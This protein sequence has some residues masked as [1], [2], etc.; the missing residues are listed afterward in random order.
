MGMTIAITSVMV[1]QW[2]SLA[3][4]VFSYYLLLLFLLLLLV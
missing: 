3:A 1:T 4:A 2:S